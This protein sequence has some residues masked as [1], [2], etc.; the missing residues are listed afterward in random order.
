M[1]ARYNPAPH[2]ENTS[3]VVVD[4]LV[5]VLTSS[6]LFVDA[7]LALLLVSLAEESATVVMTGCVSRFTVDT[8]VVDVFFSPPMFSSTVVVVEVALVV[9]G[10]AVVV[11]WHALSLLR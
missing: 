6:A 2:E 7:G 10:M 5:I 3:A 8:H 9:V 11:F 1:A 4:V